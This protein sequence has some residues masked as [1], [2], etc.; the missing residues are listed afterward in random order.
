M[1]T[2]NP[3][4]GSNEQS[5]QPAAQQ[6]KGGGKAEAA[7]QGQAEGKAT[8]GAGAGTGRGLERRGTTGRAPGALAQFGLSP[9]SFMR[10]MMEDLDRMF[11]EFGGFGRELRR[12][13][14]MGRELLRGLPAGGDIVW[15]PQVEVMEREGNLVVRADLP[16]LR[17]EDV[18]ITATEDGLVI[19]GERRREVEEERGGTYRSEVAYGSF[20][21]A[22]PLP[23]G[24]KVEDAE[25]R[26][27]N[28]VLEI[29]VPV[30]KEAQRGRQI[31][32]KGGEKGPSVH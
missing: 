32:I 23:E 9:F 17:K 11:D 2:T 1:A 8:S 26:F 14:T 4:G 31:E 18:R 10:R 16:G 21:R 29:R 20:R 25:A 6:G 5:G 12:G 3:T 28:G 30:S 19:E 7:Q 13:P 15:M 24:A 22:I 27:D